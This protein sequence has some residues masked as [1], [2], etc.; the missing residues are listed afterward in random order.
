[1][2]PSS[3]RAKRRRQLLEAARDVFAEKGYVAATVDDIVGRVEVAR[4]TF[5]L[6]FDDKLDVFGALVSDFF[7]R[8]AG[9]IQ[10]IALDAEAPSPRTQLRANLA[11]LVA[12]ARRDPAMV[13]LALSTAT[14][15]DPGLDAKLEAFYASPRQFM[16]ETLETGQAIGLVRE[17]ARGPMLS[18]AL[19][20]LQQLLLDAVSGALEQDE[21]ALVDEIM[22]FLESGLLAAASA[23]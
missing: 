15:V 2:A 19:G 14:G 22:R 21:E 18:L 7:A 12:T 6:Y 20:A 9:G 1:M 5:Y 13:K 11:R 16:D 8:L 3:R 10:S 17:G 23:R 4:G